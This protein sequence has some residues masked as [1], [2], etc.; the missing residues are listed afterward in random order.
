MMRSCTVSAGTAGLEAAAS[1]LD[2]LD[3]FMA[4]IKSGAM[5]T[6][7]KMAL[8]RRKFDLEKEKVRLEKLANIAKPA[9]IVLAKY[10]TARHPR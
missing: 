10:V 6:K 4:N 5:D 3:A 1:G 8:K 7:T 2:A 9:D